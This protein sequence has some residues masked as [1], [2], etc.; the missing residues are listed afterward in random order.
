MKPIMLKRA[1]R[2]YMGLLASLLIWILW[3]E[4]AI[5]IAALAVL[6]VTFVAFI[7]ALPERL[8]NNDD[9]W[10]DPYSDL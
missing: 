4:S 3:P 5:A 8:W 7:L 10:R 1:A 6:F 9:D 2:I